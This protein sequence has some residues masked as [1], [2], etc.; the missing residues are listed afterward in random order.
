MRLISALVAFLFFA[1]S[2]VACA[3]ERVSYILENHPNKNFEQFYSNVRGWPYTLEA[4][5]TQKI[6]G[7]YAD[8]NIGSG[9]E[10]TKALLGQPDVIDRVHQS[11]NLDKKITSWLYVL[12]M[13][14]PLIEGGIISSAVVVY[15]DESGRLIATDITGIGHAT[16]IGDVATGKVGRYMR[17][18]N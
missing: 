11:N 1:A 16:P 9:L 3:K 8:L 13:S 12:K 4:K 18:W 17:Y 14:G 15:F 5:R 6:I 7:S 10:T 2:L